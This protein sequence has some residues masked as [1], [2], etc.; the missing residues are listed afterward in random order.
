MNL[1]RE[2]KNVDP[3]L[4]TA[5][6]G[7]DDNTLTLRLLF[8]YGNA[9]IAFQLWNDR[10]NFI[11]RDLITLV[12]YFTAEDDEKNLLQFLRADATQQLYQELTAS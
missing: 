6:P 8:K 10:K 11:A 4:V 12:Q 2:L 5:Y 9:D 1:L 3:R 7:G